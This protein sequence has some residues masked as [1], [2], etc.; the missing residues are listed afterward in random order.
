L[1]RLK[2]LK[3]SYEKTT[4]RQTVQAKL[5]IAYLVNVHDDIA[6]A[7]A[8]ALHAMYNQPDGVLLPVH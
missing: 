5:K 4:D 3:I 7:L 8:L 1:P 2:S 6:Y